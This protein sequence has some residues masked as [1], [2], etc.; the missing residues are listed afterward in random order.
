MLLGTNLDLYVSL[1][2]SCITKGH[3][4][5]CYKCNPL[6][7]CEDQKVETCPSGSYKCLTGTTVMQVG[8]SNMMD[9]NLKFNFIGA[10]S[11]EITSHRASNFCYR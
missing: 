11:L 9:Y 2:L 6:S 7:S 5:S 10:A 1:S 8:K 3:S 4:L